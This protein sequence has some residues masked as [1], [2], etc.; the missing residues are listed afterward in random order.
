MNNAPGLFLSMVRDLSIL[1]KYGYN[2][3]EKLTNRTSLAHTQF[4]QIDELSG[5]TGNG[6]YTV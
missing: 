6:A 2:A 1:T 4:E 3:L 5:G